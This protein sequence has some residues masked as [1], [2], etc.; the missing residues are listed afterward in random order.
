M[1]RITPP[2]KKKGTIDTAESLRD[3]FLSGN[4][5]RDSG[6]IGSS[7]SNELQFLG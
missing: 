7:V 3:R 2:L 5:H 1:N 6:L 4:I